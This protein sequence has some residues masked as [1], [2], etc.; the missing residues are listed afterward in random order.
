MAEQ[1]DREK[2]RMGNMILMRNE[3]RRTNEN[4]EYFALKVENEDGGRERW[5]L[6]TRTEC[7]RLARFSGSLVNAMKPGRLYAACDRRGPLYL[8]RIGNWK[9]SAVRISTYWLARMEARARKN[10]EDLPKQG[11]LADLL[12]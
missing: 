12:D 9:E 10:P 2:V 8:V 7:A 5:L 6:L 1:L 11:K 4:S 3:K